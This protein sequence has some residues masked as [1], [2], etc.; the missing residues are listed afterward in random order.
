MKTKLIL[1]LAACAWLTSCAIG[2][3]Y[4]P[5]VQA[6]A[7]SWGAP[8]FNGNGAMLA[9]HSVPATRKTLLHD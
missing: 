8:T 4:T 6:H 7:A 9:P 5:D 1:I 2:P 3:D